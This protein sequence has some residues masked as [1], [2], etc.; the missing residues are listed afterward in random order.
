[1]RGKKVS[2]VVVM[3]LCASMSLLPIL[4]SPVTSPVIVMLS[5]DREVRYTANK[6]GSLMQNAIIIRNQDLF[7]SLLLLRAVAEVIYVGHGAAQGIQVGHDL[8]SWDGFANMISHIPSR[9][10]TVASCYSEHVVDIVRQK[11]PHRAILGFKGAVDVDEAAYLSAMYQAYLRGDTKRPVK[12]MAELTTVMFGK[13][14]D[15]DQYHLW[16]LLVHGVRGIWWVNYL[17]YQSYDLKV[18]YTHPNTYKSVDSVLYYD[19]GV[20]EDTCISGWNFIAHHIPEDTVTALILGIPIGGALITLAIKLA[21]YFGWIPE[22]AIKLSGAILAIIGFILVLMGWAISAL[23][24]DEK[25]AGWD[26]FANLHVVRLFGI[27]IFVEWDY[28]IG[29]SW[30]F[31]CQWFGPTVNIYPLWYGGND[32]GIGGI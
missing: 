5:G 27:P 14:F 21:I 1:M 11:T 13:I 2:I 7:S 10:I 4:S 9:A 16:T 25:G 30:W 15:P 6:M 12:L 18:A 17:D 26:Y 8:V 28:K 29:R 31:H 24:K 32:L 22:P 20:N 23:V 3:V 19:I